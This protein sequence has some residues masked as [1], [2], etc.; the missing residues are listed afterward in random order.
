[1][2]NELPITVQSPPTL[3]ASEVILALAASEGID[4]EVLTFP[5]VK[6]RLEHRTSHPDRSPRLLDWSGNGPVGLCG[7]RAA[8]TFFESFELFPGLVIRA[9]DH[10]MGRFGL[11]LNGNRLIF[12]VHLRD[13]GLLISGTPDEVTVAFSTPL[14]ETFSAALV[15]EPLEKLVDWSP[16]SGSGYLIASIGDAA[17]TEPYCAKIVTKPVEVTIGTSIQLG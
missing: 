11:G 3:I 5:Y 10:P 2:N 4:P 12:E 16:A 14:P 9:W 8:R 6:R 13:D 1:M 17:G 15:G 7:P